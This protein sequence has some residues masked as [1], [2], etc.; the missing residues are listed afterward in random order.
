[1]E[2]KEIGKGK[3]DAVQILFDIFMAVFVNFNFNTPVSAL[4]AVAIQVELSA[5]R[6]PQRLQGFPSLESYHQTGKFMTKQ[7]STD[8][9]L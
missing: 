2:M 4:D 6:V 9:I 3:D 7:E 5:W 1:M 8:F